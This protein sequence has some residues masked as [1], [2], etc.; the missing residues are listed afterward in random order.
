LPLAGDGQHS[1]P[2][3]P[4]GQPAARSRLPGHLFRAIAIVAKPRARSAPAANC[5]LAAALAVVP[6]DVRLGRREAA[7]WRCQLARLDCPHAPLRNPAAANAAGLVCAPSPTL[8]PESLLR[9]N[10][11]YRTR[12]AVSHLSSAAPAI[13]RIL[14]LH[15]PDA[16]HLAHWQ[17]HVL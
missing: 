12:S 11:R 9:G 17:L 3:L 8:V 1:L 16:R 13:H 14:G 5:S 15:A 10:V 6:A 7:E 2:R 4:V